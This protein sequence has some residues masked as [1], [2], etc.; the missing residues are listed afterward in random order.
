MKSLRIISLAIF[1]VNFTINLQAQY[2]STVNNESAY[3]DDQQPFTPGQECDAVFSIVLDS[4]TTV[5]YLYHFKDLSTGSF[6]KW[7]WDFGDGNTS[8]EQHPSHQ[9]AEPGTYTVCLTIEDENNMNNCSDQACQDIITLKYYSLGGQVYAGEHPLNNPVNEGDTGIASLYRMVNNQITF[10]EDQYFYEYGYYWF[11]YLFPGDYL[12]KIALTDNSTHFKDYFTTYYGDA[13]SWTKAEL[14]TISG[15]DQFAAD[16]H[17][18]GVKSLSSGTGAI[19]GYVKFEQGNLFNMPP[20]AQTSVI[21]ADENHNPLIY[22]HPNNSGYF[23]FSSIPFD[24]YYLSADATGKPSSTVNVAISQSVPLVEGI[25]LTVFG[26]NVNFIPEETS[27][28]LILLRIYPNPIQDHLKISLF[29]VISGPAGIAMNDVTGKVCY[30]T[31]KKLETG[32]NDI[33]IP[34]SNLQKGIYLLVIQPQGS[35]QPVTAKFVK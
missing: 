33:I 34:A 13:T 17:L 14:M 29:S 7:T 26:S 5:P 23:E 24:S 6:N 4:L 16:I 25:N 30:S 8:Q 31:I 10:V 15:T 32:F 22:T 27:H 3:L 11:G 9:Y 20:I 21:L 2:Q 19:K 1:L 12:V 28:G 35:H 18:E